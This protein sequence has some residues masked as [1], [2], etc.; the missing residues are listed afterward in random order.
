MLIQL[1]PPSPVTMGDLIETI[2]RDA[3]LTDARR[4]NLCSSLRRFCHALG[5]L[6]DV[7]VVRTFGA[8]GSVN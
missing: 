2:A 6:P 5:M 4:R 8:D 7:S 1:N 3:A